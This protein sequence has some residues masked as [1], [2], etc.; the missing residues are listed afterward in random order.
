MD[1]ISSHGRL[2][3][4]FLMTIPIQLFFVFVLSHL[5]P[6]FLD[7]ASHNLSFLIFSW[8]NPNIKP[9]L[10]LSLSSPSQRLF[11]AGGR[12]GRGNLT[13]QSTQNS[14]SLDG[15]GEGR[16][17]AIAALATAQWG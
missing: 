17:R 2:L 10:T 12:Q 8:F 1:D 3:F 4:L 11:Q 9:P 7:H 15:G 13:G 6:S 5:L 16:R 14:L